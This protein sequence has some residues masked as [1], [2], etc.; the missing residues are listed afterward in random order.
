MSKKT[1]TIL[2]IAAATVFNIFTFLAV[3]FALFFLTLAFSDQLLANEGTTSL[4]SPL[5]VVIFL[6]SIF[7]SFV[8]YRMVLGFFLR[9]VDPDE[10]FTLLFEKEKEDESE[11]ARRPPRR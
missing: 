7:L 6:A 8:I 3:F 4:L 10:H 5:F 9:K 2:F 11:H 1:N